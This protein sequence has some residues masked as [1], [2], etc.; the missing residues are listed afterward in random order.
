MSNNFSE[1]VVIRLKDE[2]TST[3]DKIA[4]SS[5][6]M[7]DI[8]K[9][10]AGVAGTYLSFAFLKDSAQ[11]FM[12]NEKAVLQLQGS[13]RALGITSASLTENYKDFA[14]SIQYSTFFTEEDALASER[15]F[16]QYKITG[17][18]MK[19]AVKVAS[20][21]ATAMGTDL[22]SASQML[23]RAGE[24]NVMMLHRMGINVTDATLKT[25]GFAGVLEEVE[26]KFGGFAQAANGG[27]AAS[28]NQMSKN[29]D[30]LKKNVGEVIGMLDKKFGVTKFWG[31]LA[32][33]IHDSV[34]DTKDPIK[35]LQKQITGI[36][37]Q[38]DELKNQQQVGHRSIGFFDFGDSAE[39]AAKKIAVLDEQLKPLKE[40]LA[41][42]VV[43]KDKN[44]EADKKMEKSAQASNSHIITEKM[45][46]EMQAYKEFYAKL[47]EEDSNTYQKIGAQRDR[48]LVKLKKYYADGVI[49]A[50]EYAKA[51][52]L[53][54]ATS[55]KKV[56][57]YIGAAISSSASSLGQNFLQM[58]KS[59]A[60]GAI[61]MANTVAQ[62]VGKAGFKGAESFGIVGSIFSSFLGLGQSLQGFFAMFDE[63]TRSEFTKLS[64]YID[65][66]NKQIDDTLSRLKS[67]HNLEDET[68]AGRAGTVDAQGADQFFG[69]G[70]DQAA[71]KVNEILG[72]QAPINPSGYARGEG[73]VAD[74]IRTNLG[75]NKIDW[76]IDEDGNFHVLLKGQEIVVWDARDNVWRPVFVYGTEA[77]TIAIGKVVLW[78]AK[79]NGLD[80]KSLGVPADQRISP[81]DS[82]GGTNGSLGSRTFTTPSNSNGGYN[83]ASGSPSGFNQQVNINVDTMDSQGVNDFLMN[84][85]APAMRHASGRR[86]V[87]LIN[88]RGVSNNI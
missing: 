60:E 70:W 78:Y 44:I 5:I 64:D 79:R 10:I 46:Q 30:D 77:F 15:L 48:D 37:S 82:S 68:K 26:K 58:Q 87:I 51:V 49:D 23:V 8:W 22:Q 54:Y 18:Q 20:D 66:V 32:K 84:R 11:E 35:E 76:N 62:T 7:K 2:F 31:D 74:W 88:S 61:G 85:L 71:N 69:V 12:A 38:I 50:K 29:F 25:R 81:S 17:D 75:W 34:E 43:Q 73:T 47:V 14:K 3:A 57:E 55:A 56:K 19:Q 86:G 65:G 9:S 16:L 72:G 67:I 59:V 28:V 4:N 63:D 39:E 83:P 27:F 40:Q 52:D 80:G 21:L 53:I 36:T 42:L 24:G 33:G 6:K 45:K 13:L 1:E 41:E